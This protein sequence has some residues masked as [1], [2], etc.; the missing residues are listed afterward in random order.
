MVLT[1]KQRMKNN[2]GSITAVMQKNLEVIPYLQLDI[3]YLCA[4]QVFILTRSIPSVIYIILSI[5]SYSLFYCCL[6]YS[7]VNPIPQTAQGIKTK[8]LRHGLDIAQVA[9]ITDHE[10]EFIL[11]LS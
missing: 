2:N 9:F 11:K 4:I 8:T 5:Y 3:S 10:Y 1:C 6:F 7:T